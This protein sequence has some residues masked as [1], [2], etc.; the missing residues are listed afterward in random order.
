MTEGAIFYKKR[1]SSFKIWISGLRNVKKDRDMQFVAISRKTPRLLQCLVKFTFLH[2]DFLKDV[3]SEIAL[4]FMAKEKDDYVVM[5]DVVRYG[6]TFERVVNHIKYYHGNNPNIKGFPYAQQAD[7][8]YVNFIDKYAINLQRDSAQYFV[9]DLLHSFMSL[10]LPFDIEHP[11][12]YFKLRGYSAEKQ[13]QKEI[14]ESFL[15]KVVQQGNANACWYEN[16][17]GGYRNWTL[18]ILQRK[19]QIEIEPE[20]VKFRFYWNGEEEVLSIVPMSPYCIVK[21]TLDHF[22]EYIQDDYQSLWTIP[23]QNALYSLMPPTTKISDDDYIN[24]YIKGE[25]ENVTF[26]SLVVWANY[27]LSLSSFNRYF[28]KDLL[29]E[30][31]PI[32]RT[33]KLFD[34]Q[35]LLGRSLAENIISL[36]NKFIDDKVVLNYTINET[37]SKATLNEEILPNEYITEYNEY[38]SSRLNHCSNLSEVLSFYFFGMRLKIEDPSREEIYPLFKRLRFGTTMQG[39]IN[40]LEA[41]LN[42]VS[43]ERMHKV[44]DRNID[45]GSIVPKY[46]FISKSPSLQYFVRTFRCG[47]KIDRFQEIIHMCIWIYKQMNSD[48]VSRR[49]LERIYSLALCNIANLDELRVLNEVYDLTMLDQEYPALQIEEI[50][51]NLVSWLIKL[52]IFKEVDGNALVIYDDIINDYDFGYPL[53]GQVQRVQNDLVKFVLALSDEG[54]GVRDEDVSN[55]FNIYSVNNINLVFSREIR[56]WINKFPKVLEADDLEKEVYT[57]SL[58]IGSDYHSK[59]QIESL[60]KKIDGAFDYLNREMDREFDSVLLTWKELKGIAGEKI[61]DQDFITE[62]LL[63][64]MLYKIHRQVSMKEPISDVA[65]LIL[66]IFLSFH[67]DSKAFFLFEQMQEKMRSQV[68]ED[69]VGR[70]EELLI[71]CTK[72][73]Q[74][75]IENY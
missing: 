7:A 24:E 67:K 23:Y 30:I 48:K 19:R 49:L 25:A 54:S 21:Q 33:I 75:V 14:I 40:I 43:L 47:E 62:A 1:Q 39:M 59:Y 17:H 31:I 72:T 4:P 6:S 26:G 37:F 64:Q 58:K 68:S 18:L 12:L 66:E 73:L 65:V 29:E 36:L 52:G 70:V 38:L 69:M 3:V 32:E 51:Y 8:Y 11:I 46:L 16:G 71:E 2:E 15:H 10:N 63:P 9:N 22:E 57:L 50:K 56:E 61:P 74:E 60:L 20:F 5:D 28:K 35:L 44:I 45:E 42:I 53:N 27:L 34:L 13:N 55:L 41:N